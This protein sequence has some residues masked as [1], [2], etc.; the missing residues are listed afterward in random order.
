MN[1]IFRYVLESVFLVFDVPMHID[2]YT[3]V[4]IQKVDFNPKQAKDSS[5]NVA[6]TSAEKKN[7]ENFQNFV[8]SNPVFMFFLLFS[9]NLHLWGFNC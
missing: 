3:A 2:V 7:S 9:L 4:G 6:E 5:T 8:N 1:G